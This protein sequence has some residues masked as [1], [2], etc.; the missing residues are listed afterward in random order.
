MPAR[1]RLDQVLD[2]DFLDDID[3]IDIEQLRSRRQMAVEVEKELSYYRRLLHGR[4]DLLRFERRRRTGEESRS[5]IESLAE[6]LSDPSRGEGHD[7]RRTILDTDLPPMPETGRREVDAVLGD[8]VLAKLDSVD[9][10]GIS[11]A[12]EAV[13]AIEREISDKR[14]QVQQVADLLSAQ[15]AE[16]YRSGTAESVSS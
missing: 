2:E 8:D 3:E 1:R 7:P 9:D 11:A 16:R 5:L 6:I 15:I 10:D 13:Q 12:L 14:H 4:M